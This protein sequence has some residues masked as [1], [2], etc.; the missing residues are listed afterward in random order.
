[1][2]KKLPNPME[3]VNWE[4]D[5]GRRKSLPV[6]CLTEDRCLEYTNNNFNDNQ[7]VKATKAHRKMKYDI[8]ESSQ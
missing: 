2:A 1:V 5:T 8:K 4:N 3:T 6:V 7:K